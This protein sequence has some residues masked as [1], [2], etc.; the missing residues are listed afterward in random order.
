[1]P[2]FTPR[3]Q[4]PLEPKYMNM[5]KSIAK[6]I[7]R[8][9]CVLFT[10]AGVNFCSAEYEQH[11]PPGHRPPTGAELTTLIKN[12]LPDDPFAAEPH[13]SLSRI[14]QYY[15]GVDDRLNL[16]AILVQHTKTGKH[17]S[18]ILKDLAQMPFTHIMTTNYDQLF[19]EALTLAGKQNFHKGVYKR[20]RNELTFKVDQNDIT[21]ERPFLYKVHGDIDD[22]A[23]IVITDE[24]YIHFILRMRD[25]DDYNPIPRSFTD[26]FANKSI[27]FIGYRLMDYNLRLLFKT[28]RWGNDESLLPRNYSIDPYPDVVIADVVDSYY[29]TSSIVVDAWRVVPYLYEE[30]FRQQ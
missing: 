3:P 12:E 7:K 14:A 28:I 2:P 17:A 19:E 20:E 9:N 24:D 22:R 18:P 27:L 29:K 16:H 23:S 13:V 10:G 5:V 11:Y 1:M 25:K 15:E 21:V 30:V 8:G 4:E 26:M 6:N